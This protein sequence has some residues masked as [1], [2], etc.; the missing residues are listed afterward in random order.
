MGCPV[1]LFRAFCETK[2][3]NHHREFAGRAVTEISAVGFY[4]C[5]S[6]DLQWT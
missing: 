5:N 2:G 4:F 1:L 3:G 6:E